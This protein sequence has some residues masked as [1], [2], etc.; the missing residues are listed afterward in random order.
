MLK[1]KRWLATSLLHEQVCN[2]AGEN[3]GRIEDVVVDPMT[4]NIDYVLMSFGGLTGMGTKLFA[5]PWSAFHI[6]DARDHVLLNVNK[7]TLERA[8]GFDRDHLPDFNDPAWRRSTYDYYGVSPAP[9]TERKVYVEHV[10]PARQGMSFGAA[11]VIIILLVAAGWATFLVSTR[12]W[13][14]TKQDMRSTF[15]SAAY[16]AKET[17]HEA[18]LTTKVKTAFALSKQV[19]AGDIDVSS[20][21][22]VVTLRGD[23]PS[24]DVRM[25]AESVAGD[26]PGVR[27]VQNHLYVT[28]GR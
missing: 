14:Q 23:V 12:G 25:K 24:Q 8:S 10:R 5:I 11:L 20:D 27:V 7:A 6:S 16:A 4:G 26:V 18:A 13:E 28:A 1:S 17:S 3:L 15:Q 21:G 9:V 22:D 19:P 2:A